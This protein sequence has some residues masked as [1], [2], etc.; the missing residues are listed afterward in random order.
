MRSIKR[1][2]FPLTKKGGVPH[3]ETTTF[4]RLFYRRMDRIQENPS[5]NVLG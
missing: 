5:R 4:Q 3:D 2:H 1:V